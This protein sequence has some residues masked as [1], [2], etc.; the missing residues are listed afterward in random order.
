MANIF[1]PT[2]E[3]LTAWQA[4]LDS[5][6]EAVRKVAEKLPP[7]GLFLLKSS[8]HRVTIYSYGEQDDGKVT[9]TVNVLGA[10]N[11]VDFE[12]QVFGIEPE[13][14]ESCDLPEP[15]EPVGTRMTQDEATDNLD[16]LRVQIRPDL[17]RLDDEGVAVRRNS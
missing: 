1:E 10:Y 3:Q 17:W 8:N 4:F 12:R 6:P 11:L 5:R 9:V 13:N 16:L 15:H 7:W 14:L 2:E